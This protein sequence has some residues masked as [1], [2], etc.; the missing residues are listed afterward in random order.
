MIRITSI[1]RN[2]PT[3]CLFS[4]HASQVSAENSWSSDWQL[5]VIHSEFIMAMSNSQSQRSENAIRGLA[6]GPGCRM[7]CLAAKLGCCSAGGRWCGRSHC[8]TASGESK[9]RS[10]R[11]DAGRS[12]WQGA[13]MHQERDW[14]LSLRKTRWN[15]I[16]G[17]L[18]VRYRVSAVAATP[19]L[20]MVT[21]DTLQANIVIRC[22]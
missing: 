9:I 21:Y 8:Q 18:G 3:C 4:L 1:H 6:W 20:Y 10:Q 7:D 16:R 12:L 13:T 11:V 14:F 17:Y 22:N 19:F 5:L 2:D 15:M